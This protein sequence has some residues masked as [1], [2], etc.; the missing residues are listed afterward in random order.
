[1]EKVG[2]FKEFVSPQDAKAISSLGY[3]RL[4]FRYW[5]EENMYRSPELI[6]NAHET[7]PLDAWAAPLY[8]QAFR[9]F[10]EEYGLHGS[11][12]PANISDGT[13]YWNISGGKE[14][15]LYADTYKNFYN[16]DSD[17]FPTY[18]EALDDCIK[19]LIKIILEY[20]Y[21]P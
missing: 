10:R 14:G 2:I 18:Q 4:G 7:V 12:E 5:T 20:A 16:W 8:Q 6:G 17:N 3:K 13:Y 11:I 1:M 9:W 19:Q 15:V 21:C